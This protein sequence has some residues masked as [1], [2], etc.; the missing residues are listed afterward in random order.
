MQHK[1]RTPI[2]MIHMECFAEIR[3]SAVDG[4]GLFASVGIKAGEL[5][6]KKSRPLVAA[7][8][9]PRLGDTCAK[10]FRSKLGEGFYGVGIPGQITEVK[11]CT[12]CRRVAYCSRV[13]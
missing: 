8:D 3:K 2:E 4:R 7:L 10:C 5:I 6:F 12:G 11:K 1:E 13:R 9:V